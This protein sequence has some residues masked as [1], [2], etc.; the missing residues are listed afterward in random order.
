M[1]AYPHCDMRVVLCVYLI[2]T[3]PANFKPT[4]QYRSSGLCVY[5]FVFIR[6]YC[7]KS[8]RQLLLAPHWAVLQSTAVM[9]CWDDASLLQKRAM[10]FLTYWRLTKFCSTPYGP[11]VSKSILKL[12][13]C[14]PVHRPKWLCYIYLC[15]TANFEF[16]TDVWYVCICS[17]FGHSHQSVC[18]YVRTLRSHIH[19]KHM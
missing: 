15:G 14:V 8:C 6:T 10:V 9:K 19:S 2:Y 13:L 5:I 7:M 17:Q 4:K 12:Y 3:E 11:Y 1:R 16:C 18:I